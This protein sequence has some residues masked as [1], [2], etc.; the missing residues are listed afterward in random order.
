MSKLKKIIASIIVAIFIVPQVALA[1]SSININNGN[2]SGRISGG[3]F[4]FGFNSGGGAWNSGNLSAFGLPQGSIAG[5]IENILSWLLLIF[6]FLGVIGFVIAGIMY[7]VAA[8]D[9]SLAERAKNAMK[10]SIIGIIV[11]LGGLVVIQAVAIALEG[12]GTF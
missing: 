6:G 12:N 2:V 10:Y 9:D 5:I 4:S 8:G 1:A 7:L 3:G 11:G